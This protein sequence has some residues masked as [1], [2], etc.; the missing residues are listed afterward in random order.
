MK[1]AVYPPFLYE[2]LRFFASLVIKPIAP[3][4]KILSKENFYNMTFLSKNIKDMVPYNQPSKVFR[5]FLV[6]DLFIYN[7]CYSLIKLL[8]LGLL[9]LII[10]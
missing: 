4:G 8:I 9:S 1:N 2:F 10:I 5:K 6:T 3:Y 7:S